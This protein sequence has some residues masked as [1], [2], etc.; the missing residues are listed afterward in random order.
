M[1]ERYIAAIGGSAGALEPLKSFFDHTP[2]DNVSY[3][4]L[5]H[6]PP[7]YQS[8][9]KDILSKHSLLEIIE[10]VD[11]MRLEKKQGLPASRG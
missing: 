7:S 6:L 1:S 3:V 8:L 5:R 9:L 10:V 2:N 4:I 11:E